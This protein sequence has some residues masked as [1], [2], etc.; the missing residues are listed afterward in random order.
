MITGGMWEVSTEDGRTEREGGGSIL[1]TCKSY[2]EKCG[3]YG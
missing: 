1:R 2:A 3:L